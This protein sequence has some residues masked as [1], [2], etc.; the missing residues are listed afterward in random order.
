MERIAW[1]ESRYDSEI[2]SPT[3]D[4]GLFQIN[5]HAH[6]ERLKELGLDPLNVDDN[7]MYARMLYDNGVKYYGDGTKDWYMSKSCWEDYIALR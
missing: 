4:F 3:N 1:C 7:I 2:V 6:G 5:N